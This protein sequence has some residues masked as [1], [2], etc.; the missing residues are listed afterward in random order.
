VLLWVQASLLESRGDRAAAL[1]LLTSVWDR[2][3]PIRF[4]LQ[5]RSLAPDLI[6]LALAT[7]DRARARA[8]ADELERAAARSS[9][10]TATAVAVQGRGLVEDD[11]DLLVEAVAR[12][13]AAV[14]RLDLT[15]ACE[16]AATAMF[17]RAREDEAVALLDEAAAVHLEL[18][19]HRDL[20]RVDA[21]L[22][23]HGRAR[24]RRQPPRP[25]HGWGSLSRKER[26]V[27][28]LVGRGLS[29]PEIGIQLYVSRRTVETH[30]SHV[31]RK[32][33]V[34]NRAQLAAA[35]VTHL[36]DEPR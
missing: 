14:R 27:V 15:A 36:P 26:E 8:V 29:N 35:A 20:A 31:F 12:Y 22:R 1:A 16:D 6:R 3:E 23:A 19:A 17:G 30:L 32:L 28:Q 24:R 9:S 34:I 13:R 25:E 5:Y 4:L 18:G 7:G 2:T 33:G 10:V 21:I 11:P